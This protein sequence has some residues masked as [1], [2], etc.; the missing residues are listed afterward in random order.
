MLRL[1]AK[2]IKIHASGGVLSQLDDP[3]LP[4]F[5]KEELEAI[6]D[7]ASRMERIVGAHT[8]GKRGMMAAVEAGVK[9]LEHGT[10]IDEEVADAMIEN[11][12]DEY[13][14]PQDGSDV[15]TF[16]SSLDVV[17]WYNETIPSH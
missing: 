8:H 12:T 16:A 17:V 9:T 13:I 1:G 11:D 14:P 10:F 6:V 7:E 2:V 3:H 15:G 5:S 4:Q